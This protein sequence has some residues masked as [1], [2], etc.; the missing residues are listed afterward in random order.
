ML[1]V[2]TGS[3]RMVRFLI[4]RFRGYDEVVAIDRDGAVASDF[5]GRFIDDHDI[6]FETM[7]A[8]DLSFA[9]GS[10]DLASMSHALCEFTD[11]DRPTVLQAIRRLVR[12]AGALII[13]DT[14]RDQATDPE[15]THVLLHDWWSDVDAHEGITHRPFRS[16][17]EIVADLEALN[18][19]DLRLF[20]VPDAPGDPF[21]PDQLAWIDGVIDASLARV[22]DEP[23]LAARGMELRERMYR[24]GFR[25]AT[26][27]V[28][29]GEIP[30]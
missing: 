3:G 12:T 6:R 26:A 18:L 19:H 11:A 8:L 7:D 1:D 22:D 30:A 20:D 16:R 13:S 14:P 17:A 9:P 28:A 27:Q 5:A 23:R 25:V 10:F 2:A 15:M 4:D 24:V 21:D 29:F